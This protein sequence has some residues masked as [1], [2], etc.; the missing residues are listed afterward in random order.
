MAFRSVLGGALR[1]ILDSAAAKVKRNACARLRRQRW[2]PSVFGGMDHQDESF[3]SGKDGRIVRVD[4]ARES[5]SNLGGE[6]RV[7]G[8]AGYSAGISTNGNVE[9]L[10]SLA[11]FA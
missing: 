10:F 3:A 6:V 11:A 7:V 8:E 2:F 9:S 1:A 4:G 5:R